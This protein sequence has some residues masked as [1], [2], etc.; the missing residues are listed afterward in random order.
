M[1]S[2][3]IASCAA[4]LTASLAVVAFRRAGTTS[5]EVFGRGVVAAFLAVV[6][7]AFSRLSRGPALLPAEGKLSVGALESVERL[8]P[9]PRLRGQ[10]RAARN[11][12]DDLGQFQDPAGGP[13]G[14]AG[15]LGG[16]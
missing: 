1:P 14:Q 3:A 16:P 9:E 13:K 8:I 11:I 15:Q 12:L 7:V 2:S 10:G 6:R 4:S 5:A